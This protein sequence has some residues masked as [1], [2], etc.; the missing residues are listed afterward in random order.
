MTS[1]LFTDTQETE[2]CRR[3]TDDGRSL[4]Q[5]AEEYRCTV[6]TVR[7]ILKRQGVTTRVTAKLH[8]EEFQRNEADTVVDLYRDGLTVAEIAEQYGVGYKLIAATL[9]T[10]QEPTRPP[11][12]FFRRFGQ[13]INGVEVAQRYLDG[14][15]LTT[16]AKH[17]GVSMSII[18]QLLTE[19][20]VT[21]SIGKP[22]AVSDEQILWV[23]AQYDA[24]RS[25]QDI[26]NELGCS[27]N[28]ISRVLRGQ[29]SSIRAS[30]SNHPG[31]NGG[32]T[33]DTGGYVL[34]TPS[35]FDKELC[36][37]NSHGYVLEHRIVMARALGRPLTAS[38]TVHHINGQR[39]DNRLENL[40]LRQVNHG[41]GIVMTC[42]DCGSHNVVATPL[43]E[44]K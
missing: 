23:L 4:R 27:Q 10:A 38:E 5:L 44:G 25:Q 14:E 8:S 20:G 18:R 35:E 43:D 16:L 31:W 41:S 37:P 11:G 17:Y 24:G 26:A 21:I 6:K 12:Y 7:N 15:A 19:Q 32:K 9:K 13:D 40:Q 28:T 33:T 2:L 29:R 42:G 1:R 34:V 39:R 3:Y 36:T 30:G 22:R